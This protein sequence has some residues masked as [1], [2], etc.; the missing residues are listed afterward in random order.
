MKTIVGTRRNWSLAGVA[1][2]KVAVG[3]LLVSSFLLLSRVLTPC[4]HSS[5]CELRAGFLCT[6]WPTLAILVGFCF[7]SKS[8]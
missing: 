5:R 1:Y 4:S 7:G 3:S 2:E 6:L 8:I